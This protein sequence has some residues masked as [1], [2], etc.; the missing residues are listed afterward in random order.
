VIRFN[1]IYDHNYEAA[2]ILNGD[3]DGNWS[4]DQIYIYGNQIWD[5]D[6]QGISTQEASG[7]TYADIYIFSN[8]IYEQDLRGI[9]ISGWGTYTIFNNTFAE[10]GDNPSAGVDTNIYVEQGTATVKN[11][12]FIKGRPNEGDFTQVDIG[13]GADEITT[14]DYNIYYWPLETSIIDWGDAGEKTVVQLQTL[15]GAYG[16][17]EVNGSDDNP[18]LT[19]WA[20][21][22]YTIAGVG[23]GCVDGGDDMG[24]GNIASL[25]INGETVNV[26]WDFALGSDTDWSGTI[27]VI[28]E[29]SRDSIG[30]DQGAYAYDPVDTTIRGVTP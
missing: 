13:A 12:I 14:F 27:P 3:D 26:P 15:G 21:N 7:E 30:W 10:N 2:I 8:I 29:E 5:N 17:Q 20:N 4:A 9:N 23:S 24:S 6:S 11:N 19:D 22:D 18:D 1:N 16:N 28:D 25:T